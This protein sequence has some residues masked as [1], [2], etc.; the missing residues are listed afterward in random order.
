MIAPSH[1]DSDGASD[2]LDQLVHRQVLLPW[3]SMNEFIQEFT[4]SGTALR[5]AVKDLI[6]QEGYITSAGSRALAES[7]LPA[8][9]DAVC[10][11]GARDA[12]VQIVGRTNMHELAYGVTGINP[13]YGTPVNPLGKHLVP[14]GSS[15][16]SAVAVALDRADVAFGSDT[17]GSVRIPAACCGIAGL[18]TTHGRVSLEGVWPLAP[19]LDSI[20]PMAKDVRGL[21][22]GM[23]LLEPGFELGG[24]T[25]L[26]VGKIRLDADPVIERAL[27]HALMAV[28]WDVIDIDVPEW[29]EVTAQC[30]TLIKAEGWRNDRLLVEGVPEL[31]GE[32]VRSKLI[33]GSHVSEE[34]LASVRAE[35]FA[36]RSRLEILHQEFDLLVTPTLSIF[37]PSIQDALVLQDGRSRCTLPANFAGTPALALPIP[38]SGDL[39][40][41]IQLMASMYGEELLLR[42]GL[43]LE[44]A[45][46]S[47]S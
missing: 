11:Q 41:S 46:T 31:I 43:E 38:S 8:E 25:T 34:E 26:R 20:G 16:G 7:S 42:A 14:G 45:V 39:P 3:N 4:T 2:R 35:Q 9:R 6:D 19:S 30:L 32:D 27:S 17:G 5:L 18:K 10:L 28:G 47:K 37:P 23:K 1:V 40:A 12:H 29:F 33:S 44:E 36:W 13:W 22:E 24:N 21:I 15:S